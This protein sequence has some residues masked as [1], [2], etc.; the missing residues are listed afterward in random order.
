MVVP[1]HLDLKDFGLVM[2]QI[3]MLSS[4]L[5]TNPSPVL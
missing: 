1:G 2:H 4:M 3:G 5:G